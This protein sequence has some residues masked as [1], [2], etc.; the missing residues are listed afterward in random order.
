MTVT[1]ILCMVVSNVASPVLVFTIIGPMLRTLT[2]DHPLSKAL[3][4][5][6]AY[7]AN[8]GGMSSTIASPQNLVTNQNL[9]TLKPS[10]AV[11]FGEWLIFSTPIC[12]I[13]LFAV[14]TVLLFVYPCKTLLPESC[15]MKSAG[16]SWTKKQ[17]YVSAVAV[18]TILLWV[19]SSFLKGYI[20]HMGLLSAV[21]L[22]L[23]FG[24][25]ILGKDDFNGFMWNIVVLAMGGNALGQ[26]VESSGLL[27]FIGKAIGASLKGLSQYFTLCI[28]AFA[29]LIITTFISH[30]VGAIIFL[31]VVKSVAETMPDPHPKLFIVLG[32]LMCS[33]GM[34]MP[35]SGFP[36]MSA[37][38]QEDATGRNIINTMDFVK[39]GLLGSFLV[40]IVVITV[41][42]GLC[43]LLGY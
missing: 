20:G 18:L 29:I 2:A 7:A 24:P 34:G 40:Y 13:G 28:F 27:D 11:S 17:Y 31:P 37:V 25:G 6:V 39:T 23:Y 36:N 21:P 1:A 35:I 22:V 12:I 14:W 10:A 15:V 26:A 9:D 41:G 42:Y 5:G 19:F 43:S 4:L 32:G 30:T 38:S 33:V 16:G 3:V 8:I